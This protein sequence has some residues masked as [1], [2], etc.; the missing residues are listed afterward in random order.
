LIGFIAS[1]GA[2]SSQQA[3]AIVFIPVTPF[4]D[5]PAWQLSRFPPGNSRRKSPSI[6]DLPMARRLACV[7]L[8]DHS[9]NAGEKVRG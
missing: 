6:S 7:Q 2:T 4:P 1:L 9:E 3:E 8:G 5:W